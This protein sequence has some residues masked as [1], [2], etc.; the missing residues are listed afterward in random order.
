MYILCTVYRV[1]QYI[2]AK[3]TCLILRFVDIPLQTIIQVASLQYMCLNL[4][5]CI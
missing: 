5:L 2:F 4:V 3:E 1:C